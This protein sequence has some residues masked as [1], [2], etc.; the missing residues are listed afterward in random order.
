MDRILSEKK[1][2]RSEILKKRIEIPDEKITADSNIIINKLLELE[3]YKRSRTIMC[4]VDFKKE[5]RSRLIIEQALAKDK[6]VLVPIITKDTDGR[7]V[8]RASHLIS[9][10]DDLESGTMGIL[11]PKPECRRYVDPFEIDFFVV[12]GVAFDVHKN[13]LGYGAGFHDA[14]FQ[15]VRRDCRKVAVCFDFQVFEHIPIMDYDVPVDMIL[16]ELRTIL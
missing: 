6:R 16:T 7:K 8:M 12:P 3:A 9:F 4:F 1:A 15:L 11:E 5:V 13:R 10:E 2:L 14:M